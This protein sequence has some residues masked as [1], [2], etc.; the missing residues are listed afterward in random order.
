MK[1]RPALS[2]SGL[3]SNNNSIP[4]SSLGEAQSPTQQH[5]SRGPRSAHPQSHDHVTPPTL[6]SSTAFQKGKAFL[7]R[8]RSGSSLKVDMRIEEASSYAELSHPGWI[9]S[10]PPPSGV[11]T[12]AVSSNQD[13]RHRD[14]TPPAKKIGTMDR[15]VRGL[16]SAFEF[17]D[18]R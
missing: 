11:I 2:L 3:S 13:A 10:S 14:A 9:P 6:P 17:V 4:R 18:G 5:H 1:Q 7:R 16:D 12:N 8:V 15:I